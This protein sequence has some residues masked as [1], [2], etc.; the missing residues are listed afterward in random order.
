MNLLEGTVVLPEGSDYLLQDATNKEKKD[1]IRINYLFT[2]ANPKGPSATAKEKKNFERLG[3]NQER[4]FCFAS[5]EN[6]GKT[7]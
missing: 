3:G 2:I 1:T 6:C 5:T 4:R 7:A